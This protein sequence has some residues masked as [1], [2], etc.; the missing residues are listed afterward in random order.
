MDL[1]LALRIHLT[2]RREVAEAQSLKI[3]SLRLRVSA[4]LRFLPPATI[5][6]NLEDLRYGE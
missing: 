4:P 5:K 3:V 2:Q 6:A 1:D